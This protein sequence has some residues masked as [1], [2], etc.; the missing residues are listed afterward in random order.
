[1]PSRPSP[2]VIPPTPEKFDTI[3]PL[4]LIR[5][6]G[7]ALLAAILFSYLTVCLIVYQGGWQGV[8][9]PSAI[10]DKTPAQYAIPFE[11]I[12]F[13]AAATGSPRLTA[14]WMPT[15]SPTAP[16]ILFLH[17]RFGSLSRSI[18]QLELL[19]RANVNIFAI[20]YRGYGQSAGPH[21]NEARMQEDTAAALDYLINTRH[22]P[23]ARIVPYGT[24]VGAVLAARLAAQHPELPAY[25]LDYPDTLIVPAVV[26]NDRTHLLPMRL[27]MQEHFDLPAALAATHQSKLLLA[28]HPG[29]Y[30][31]RRVKANQAEFRQA[32]DPKLTVTFANIHAED[33]Y[34]STLRRFLDE[35]VH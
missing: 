4:W 27:L 14:W 7:L 20:D 3:D 10:I 9:L 18:D 1:M 12:H 35:N 15:D 13:D 24:G 25:I 29:G 8:L 2:I 26:S 16:T 6:V 22:I 34:L 11:T 19:R 28:D 21:P 23:A 30:E 17:D 31:S 32:P 5:A 33:A